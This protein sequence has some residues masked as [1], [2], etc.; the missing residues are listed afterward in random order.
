MKRDR[1]EFVFSLVLH[2]IFVGCVWR[3]EKMLNVVVENILNLFFGWWLK[4][5]LTG[6]SIILRIDEVTPTAVIVDGGTAGNG[7]R[8]TVQ[9]H[10]TL[11]GSANEDDGSHF[12]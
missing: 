8:H 4:K 5:I 7:G 11:R 12:C 1:E 10:P 9:C 2:H 3:L 6:F